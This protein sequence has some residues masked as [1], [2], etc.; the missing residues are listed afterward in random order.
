MPTPGSLTS[1]LEAP[2]ALGRGASRQG[3]SFYIVPLAP[4]NKA[5]LTGHI[6]GQAVIACSTESFLHSSYCDPLYNFIIS[7]E[8]SFFLRSLA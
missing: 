7:M 4:A 5:G 3:M 6:P 8:T 1:R 2:P